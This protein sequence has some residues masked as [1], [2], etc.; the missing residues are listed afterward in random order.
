MKRKRE[1]VQRKQK[2]R[3]YSSALKTRD[4]ARRASISTWRRRRTFVALVRMTPCCPCQL[5]KNQSR[6]PRN[7]IWHRQD[8]QAWQT[9]QKRLLEGMR[10]TLAGGSTLAGS[11]DAASF[12]RAWLSCHSAI[13]LPH[14]RIFPQ[15][16][17]P[18]ISEQ[19]EQQQQQP[20]Q[21]PQSPARLTVAV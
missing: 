5:E 19:P 8:A 16:R 15:Q 20:P 7:R 13:I 10:A 21:Q 11:D 9:G 4:S 2:T 1:T 18:G 17:S 3:R 12:P 14:C 6:T